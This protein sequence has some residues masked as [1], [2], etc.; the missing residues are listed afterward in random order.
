MFLPFLYGSF[1]I[2]LIS[3]FPLE[4][5]VCNNYIQNEGINIHCKFQFVSYQNNNRN[6]NVLT[7]FYTVIFNLKKVNRFQVHREYNLPE[8]V[9][10]LSIFRLFRF[11]CAKYLATA[12][13][14]SSISNGFAKCVIAPK[15]IAS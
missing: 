9:F 2:I 10:F 1:H 13:R 4:L 6:A 12:T 5:K 7:K 3:V 11:Y 14:I 15:S 8:N